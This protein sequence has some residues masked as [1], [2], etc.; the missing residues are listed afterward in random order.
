MTI[1][2]KFNKDW[3]VHSKVDGGGFTDIQ[4]AWWSH[5]NI[6]IFLNKEGRLKIVIKHCK[7]NSPKGREKIQ[8][9]KRYS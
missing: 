6:F 3:F 9:P 7:G 5:K 2:T 1:H 4:T 8:L